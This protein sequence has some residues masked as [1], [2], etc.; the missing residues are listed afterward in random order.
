MGTP[1]SPNEPGTDLTQCFGPGTIFGDV[2]TPKFIE[3]RLFDLQP[4]ELF[5]PDW[6]QLLLAMHLLEQTIDPAV[7]RIFDSVFE[8]T[9]FWGPLQTQLI[10]HEFIDPADA[11]QNNAPPICSLSRPN[12]LIAPAGNVAF[13]GHGE[14]TW[15]LEGL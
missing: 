10:V 9:V 5:N 14:I 12:Q 15:Q 4:G 6:E 7:Y 13:N 11:F 1:L 8:W 2:P 3:V